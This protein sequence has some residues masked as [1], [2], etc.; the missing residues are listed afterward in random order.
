MP[1]R[2]RITKGGIVY[3][4]LNRANGRLKIF[5]KNLDFLAFE[6]ILAEGI[7]RFDMRICSYCIMSNHWH[8]LLWPPDDD[9]MPAFM[10]WITMTHTQRWHAAHGTTGMGHLYQ[11]RYK[12]FPIQSNH[13]YFKAASYIE[14]NPLR[15]KMVTAAA[16]WP[17]SSLTRRNSSAR[18][19][20]LSPGPIPLPANWPEIVEH[21]FSEQETDDFANCIKRGCPYGE[22]DWIEETAKQLNLESTLRKRGRP[23]RFPNAG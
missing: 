3:H 5:K 12:S 7:K 23:I 10:H 14:A 6:N 21:P 4:V 9:S 1:S 16:D 18:L 11:G 19:F 20:E 2:K 13:R 22:K 17:W 15:A 8:M